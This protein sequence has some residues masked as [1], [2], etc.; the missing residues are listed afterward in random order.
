MESSNLPK[1]LPTRI[2]FGSNDKF[3]LKIMNRGI[4]MTNMTEFPFQKLYAKKIVTLFI[5]V[6]LI[7]IIAVVI[8]T[9]TK[10]EV[11]H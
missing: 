7:L 11:F 10:N 6:G 4:I 1:N 2:L 8:F 9:L 5:L 3:I